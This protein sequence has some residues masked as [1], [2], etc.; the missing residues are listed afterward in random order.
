[1][2][3]SIAI[4][5][6]IGHIGTTTQAIQAVLTLKQNNLKTCYL[7]MNRNDYLDNLLALYYQA[8]NKRNMITF[9]GIDM[10]KRNF[11]KTVTQ[12][13]WDYIVRDFGVANTE[14]FEESSFAEQP[15]K[16]VVC[17]SKPNEIFQIQD[18]LENPIYDDAFFI[19]FFVSEE[20][21]V[22]VLSSMGQRAEKTFFSGI[23]L[24]PYKLESESV[25]VF[26]KI[27]NKE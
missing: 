3:K 8:E 6:C 26:Q 15:L 11:A 27:I 10:Y 20:E 1:M 13:K 25:R 4:A 17:G 2:A 14:T 9:S 22:S 21:R 12:Q 16:I 19:F 24:D 5:G 7:E 18:L 23:I